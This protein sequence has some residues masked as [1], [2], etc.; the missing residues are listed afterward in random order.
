MPDINDQLIMIAGESASGK[1]ASLAK[2]QNQSRVMYLNCESGKRL[3]FPNQFKSYVITDPYQVHEAFMATES[4]GPLESQIDTI[5]IDTATFL[6]EMFESVHVVGSANTMAAWGDYAQFWK[7]LMQIY[8]A[9]SKKSVIFLAHTKAELD[10]ASMEMRTA[11]PVK[12]S[13]K[14]NGLEA[15]FSTVVATKKVALSKLEPYKNKMLNITEDD[16]LL[17]YK[18]VFQTRLT[19]ETRG[20]RIRSPMGMFTKEETFM[21]NDAQLLLNHLNAYYGVPA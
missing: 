19:K 16:E 17:G 9:R 4:G 20:E 14:N 15:Y 21:D 11:V 3:P 7:N 18:H 5:V 8:V 1:S 13:L 2:L 12:G 6:M 10:E